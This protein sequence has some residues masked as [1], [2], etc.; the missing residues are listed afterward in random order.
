MMKMFGKEHMKN[1]GSPHVETMYF[2]QDLTSVFIQKVKHTTISRNTNIVRNRRN[3]LMG[4]DT[5]SCY[6]KVAD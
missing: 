3:I 6:D 4:D 2:K 1:N 5:S